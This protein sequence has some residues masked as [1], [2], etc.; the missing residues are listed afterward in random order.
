M[1]QKLLS[2]EILVKDLDAKKWINDLINGK[3]GQFEL[4]FTDLQFNLN[5]LQH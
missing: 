2:K 4:K 1:N 5:L 3:E